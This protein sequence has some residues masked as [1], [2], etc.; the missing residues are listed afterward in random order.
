MIGDD[1]KQY[2]C[3]SISGPT[4]KTF[5]NWFSGNLLK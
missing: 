3:T 1:N 4:S 5:E 2:T